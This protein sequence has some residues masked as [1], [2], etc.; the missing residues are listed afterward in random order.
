MT[1]YKTYFIH[2]NSSTLPHYFAKAC[3]APSIFFENKQID[4]QNK[5]SDS[6]IVSGRKWNEQCNCS[7]EVI[8]TSENQLTQVSEN[9]Y[10]LK[11]M[12]PI[13]R[14]KHVY[15]EDKDQM[16]TTLWNITEGT[17]FM[18]QR[19]A[20]VSKKIQ[21]DLISVEEIDVKVLSRGNT[22]GDL[23][24]TI[25]FYDRFLGG[26]SMLK[27]ATADLSDAKLDASEEFIE[28]IS[29][30]NKTILNEYQEVVGH[31]I[32]SDYWSFFKKEEDSKISLLKKI[33]YSDRI[34]Q[35]DVK[36]FASLEGI[37]IES[38]FDQILIDKINPNSLTYLISIVSSYGDGTGLTMDN[39]FADLIMHKFKQE[40]VSL[41]C[42]LVGLHFGYS[43]FR[44]KYTALNN[45]KVV[46]F[47]LDNKLDYYLLESVF[48]YVVNRRSSTSFDY[49]DNIVPK[50]KVIST[51]G[52][53]YLTILDTILFT[54]KKPVLFDAAY[55]EELFQS[56]NFD[57]LFIS[58]Y[59]SY[60]K[61]L[62]P[63]ATVNSTEAVSYFQQE[64]K[65]S[66]QLVFDNIIR[67]LQ[68]DFKEFT[69]VES[70]TPSSNDETVV[71][72]MPADGERP[73]SKE[74]IG[75]VENSGDVNIN[76][77]ADIY[78]TL[79]LKKLQEIAKDKKIRGYTKFK[80]NPEDI[81]K[82]IALIKASPTNLYDIR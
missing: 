39:F 45:T 53:N 78:H 57:P 25:K 50:Q 63:F 37:K 30:F 44:N 20:S 56:S 42:F 52:Y 15:F 82:L 14:I 5:V 61:L 75:E 55:W 12:L 59:D 38:K 65:E 31:E 76:H 69:K 4:F 23:S 68:A 58:V 72:V 70:E 71:A 43:S 46:K 19:L 24:T 29:Y 64:C 33:I 28:T 18:P 2:I 8:V 1:T 17:A 80:N 10:L 3:I 60:K 66:L 21:E 73:G 81:S 48:Q 7:V 62:P 26:I 34:Q 77:D 11:D 74:D 27:I 40:K 79:P 47:T 35:S 41:V 6:I 22:V 36:N 67:K 16:E 51:K 54:K 32:M 49:L 13:S 9:Y